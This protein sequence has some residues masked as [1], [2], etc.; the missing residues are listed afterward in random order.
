MRKYLKTGLSS[1]EAAFHWFMDNCL[2]Y[3]RCSNSNQIFETSLRNV[4]REICD[5]YSHFYSIANEKMVSISSTVRGKMVAGSSYPLEG[6]PT[7]L[8]MCL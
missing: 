3:S 5:C 7:A 4:K 1:C 8:L 6:S 2:I